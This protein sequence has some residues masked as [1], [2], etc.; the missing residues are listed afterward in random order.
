MLAACANEQR[1]QTPQPL[2]EAGETVY[3]LKGRIVGRD[4]GD[5]TLRVDHEAI[6]G[7]MDAMTMD[8]PVRGA[9][10]GALPPNEARVEARLHVHGD[11][12]WITDVKKVS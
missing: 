11:R 10:V 1:S 9:A 2:S 3:V 8:Y 7:Y 4:A 12:Y 5:N 6:P